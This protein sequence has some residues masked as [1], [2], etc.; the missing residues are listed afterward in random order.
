MWSTGTH[1]THMGLYDRSV[2][3]DEAQK[4][5][6]GVRESRLT[7]HLFS[8]QSDCSATPSGAVWG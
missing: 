7:C 4:D 6:G 2:W 1:Q 5:G 3:V 8:I